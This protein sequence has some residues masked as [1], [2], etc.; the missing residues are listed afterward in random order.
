MVESHVDRNLA[1]VLRR[2][3]YATRAVSANLWLSEASGFSLGFEHFLSIDSGRQAKI[4][5]GLRARA[6]WALEAARAEVDDG[7]RE[8]GQVLRRWIDGVGG[9]PFFW[10]VNLTECHSPY[11]PPRPYTDV[12]LLDRLRAAED[13]RRHLTLD[14]I[15]SACVGGHVVPDDALE[16]MRHLYARSI[17]YMDDWLADVLEA[18]DRRGVLDDTLVLVTSDHGENLGE[19]GLM[20]HALS[21]DNRLLSVPLVASGVGAPSG[22]HARSLAELP[23]MIASAVGLDDHPWRADDLPAGA[24][25]AELDPP[26]DEEDPRA[27]EAIRQWGVGAEA[28]RLLTTPRTCA[29]DGALKLL[30]FGAEEHVF[31]LDADPLELRPLPTVNETQEVARLRAA[32]EHP[33]VAATAPLARPADASDEELRE[34]EDRMRLLGYM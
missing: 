1:E 23:R 32:L 20:A 28:L 4:H 22:D 8:A 27:H 24:A 5:G 11:L 12:S 34:L 16:R 21:L 6:S 7:A 19:S 13:A 29:T 31:D 2:A 3:G 30:R 14:R 26:V 10:F 33:S 18:L 17:R 25:V 9:R 15:W